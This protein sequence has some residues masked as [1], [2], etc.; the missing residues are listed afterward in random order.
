MCLNFFITIFF[1]F[2]IEM[3]ECYT[4]SLHRLYAVHFSILSSIKN[5]TIQNSFSLWLQ[6]LSYI[7]TFSA[8]KCCTTYRKQWTAFADNTGTEKIVR[9]GENG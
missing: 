5:F 7:S 8:I 4:L 6:N 9:L 3:L 1:L 2:Q